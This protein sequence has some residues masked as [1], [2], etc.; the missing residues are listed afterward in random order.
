[1]SCDSEPILSNVTWWRGDED[2]L[3]PPPPAVELGGDVILKGDPPPPVVVAGAVVLLDKRGNIFTIKNGLQSLSAVR[4]P[5]VRSKWVL[6]SAL[7]I[8]GTQSLW[9]AT[10]KTWL[11][12]W[13][14]VCLERRMKAGA[15]WLNTLKYQRLIQGVGVYSGNWSLLSE[16]SWHAGRVM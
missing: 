9:P 6:I 13:K 8:C 12:G 1:M 4:S 11:A 2:E 15:A 7:D 3:A 16:E 5:I 10:C 14:P